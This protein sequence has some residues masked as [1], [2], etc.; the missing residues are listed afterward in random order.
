MI[1]TPVFLRMTHRTT[2]KSAVVKRDFYV[3]NIRNSFHRIWVYYPDLRLRLCNQNNSSVYV[4]I[5][6]IIDNQSM[7]KGWQSLWISTEGRIMIRLPYSDFP[8]QIS[9]TQVFNNEQCLLH[10]KKFTKKY[11]NFRDTKTSRGSIIFIVIY[12]LVW[13]H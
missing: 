8:F 13:F 2:C 4:Y 1:I 9:D 12:S 6:S 10:F 5:T 3:I 7:N 11:H